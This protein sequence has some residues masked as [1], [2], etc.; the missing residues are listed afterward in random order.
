VEL[1][2]VEVLMALEEGFGISITDDEAAASV[3]P[4]AVVIILAMSHGPKDIV[5][6]NTDVGSFI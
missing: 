1:D 5:V 4:S 6:S 3:N 2:G